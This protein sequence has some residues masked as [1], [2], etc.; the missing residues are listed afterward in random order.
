[1]PVDRDPWKEAR[2]LLRAAPPKVRR[3]LRVNT[4]AAAGGLAIAVVDVITGTNEMEIYRLLGI[5]LAMIGIV[6]MTQVY[7][8]HHLSQHEEPGG[9]KISMFRL[10]ST[11]LHGVFRGVAFLGVLSAL[12]FAVAIGLFVPSAVRQPLLVIAMAVLAYYTWAALRTVWHVTDFLYQQARDQAEAAA[13]ARA[14]AVEAQLTALQAQMQPHFLFNALN[15]IAALVRTDARQAEH[16]VENLAQVLR[17]G[18]DRSRQSMGTVH[19][20]V[21][22]IRAWL[23][24]EQQ[25]WGDRL[26]IAWDVAE[27]TLVLPLPPMTLQPLVEN[28][29]KHG[30]GGR[31]AGG[32]ITIGVARDARRLHLT[33]TD[34]GA[35][36]AAGAEDGTGLGNLKQRLRTQFGDAARVEFT[37]GVHGTVVDMFL[38]VSEEA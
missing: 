8:L 37:G 18:L 15:T 11:R 2:E 25:R 38:P 36:I 33:V 12:A 4:L 35:G 7:V 10:H 3:V 20:E 32:H 24:V 1:M 9:V 13:Q 27:D 26:S 31:I 23:A 16:T 14:A 19:E 30:L 6:L 34:D 29:L 21:E 22:F 28:A 5:A 17:R